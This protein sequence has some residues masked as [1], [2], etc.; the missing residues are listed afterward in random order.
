MANLIRDTAI[1]KPEG[2][3]AVLQCGQPVSGRNRHNA[4]RQGS[5][6]WTC[7]DQ[8]LSGLWHM[9][10]NALGHARIVQKTRAE[11]FPWLASVAQGVDLVSP[12][13]FRR[14]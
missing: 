7:L 12:K 11:S 2:S 9:L 5:L 1:F 13:D 6:P 8:E 3:I 14:L 4:F 10:E